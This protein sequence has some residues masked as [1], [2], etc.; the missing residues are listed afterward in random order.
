MNNSFQRN[1]IYS[2]LKIYFFMQKAQQHM[3]DRFHLTS[4]TK[5]FILAKNKGTKCFDRP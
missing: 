1:Y 5:W 4:Q 2:I 3:Q